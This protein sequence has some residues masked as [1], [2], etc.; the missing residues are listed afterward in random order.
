[1]GR[2][3]IH[4]QGIVLQ[5]C[6]QSQLEPK[7]SRV[8][9][10]LRLATSAIWPEIVSEYGMKLQVRVFFLCMGEDNT[11]T[12]YCKCLKIVQIQCK[13]HWI[14]KMAKN[15]TCTKCCEGCRN[16]NGGCGKRCEFCGA[17]R[18]GVTLVLVQAMALPSWW[19]NMQM[20]LHHLRLSLSL[21]VFIFQGF[22][23]F[24]QT[25]IVPVLRSFPEI[26]K[27]LR[28][29]QCQAKWR[30]QWCAFFLTCKAA[31]Q[32]WQTNQVATIVQLASQ[33]EPW[34]N[35]RSSAKIAQ[36]H[37]ASVQLLYFGGSVVS[38]SGSGKTLAY[39]LPLLQRHVLSAD[40]SDTSLKLIVRHPK[41]Y[42]H[43]G[44][45]IEEHAGTDPWDT[46]QMDGQA[47][48]SFS[49][50]FWDIL[51]KIFGFFYFDWLWRS[52]DMN[53]SPGCGSYQWPGATDCG[54]SQGCLSQKPE[55]LPG[56]RAT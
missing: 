25:S 53:F 12:N 51:V 22:F 15:E 1:M 14:S 41:W 30:V 32:W 45:E 7:G 49:K 23:A 46:F 13:N 56:V 9:L 38:S 52:T 42:E 8:H 5:T 39:L 35:A 54:S 24:C 55:R 47:L 16:E 6:W 27:G 37:F 17:A 29:R 10:Q 11:R 4:A 34:A 40:P 21:I 31:A 50:T 2:K 44:K 36:G 33:E 43:G 19:Q 48:F 3:E 26:A 20:Y 18:G 28:L